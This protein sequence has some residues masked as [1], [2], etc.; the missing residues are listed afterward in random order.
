MRRMLTNK[1]VVDV[2]NKAI[3]D[4]EITIG[5]LPEIESG[6][7]GKALIVNSDE[8]GVEWGEVGLS[9]EDQEKLDN[10]LQLPET[11][12]LSNELV[13]ID[14]DG[15]Q[16]SLTVGDG[17]EIANGALKQN[18]F[19]N[20]TADFAPSTSGTITLTQAQKDYITTNYPIIKITFSDN[21]IGYLTYQNTTS[22][23]VYFSGNLFLN[24]STSLGFLYKS[25]G[26]IYAPSMYKIK[27]EIPVNSL[28]IGYSKENYCLLSEGTG[29]LNV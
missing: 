5:G 14:Q 17:L 10:S 11:A 18:S 13:I 21:T 1:N 2:V 12:P 22:S 16:N 6:D 24:S 27:L 4:G 19:I 26:V 3:D 29:I 20:L 28:N 9:P 7:A 8:T 25:S 15:E 23:F